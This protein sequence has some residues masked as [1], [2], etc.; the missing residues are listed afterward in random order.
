MQ[1]VIIAVL[2]LIGT[3]SGSYFS[4]RKGQILMEYKISQLEEKVNKHN[5]LIERVYKLEEN[6]AV[7]NEKI[8]VANHR[9]EDIERSMTA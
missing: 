5:N 1:T 3:L 2:S 7:V 4:N 8:A 9:I 6:E